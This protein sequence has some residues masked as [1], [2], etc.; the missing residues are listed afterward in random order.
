[1]WAVI[2]PDFAF[3]PRTALSLKVNSV[4]FWVMSRAVDRHD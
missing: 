1:L 2:F 4:A 3:P